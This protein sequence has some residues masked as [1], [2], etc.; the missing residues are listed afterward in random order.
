M[1]DFFSEIGEM[2]SNIFGF[3]QSCIDGITGFIESLKGFWGTAMMILSMFPPPV[4]GIFVAAFAL[5]VAFVVIELLR[6]FL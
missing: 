4:V 5:L 2:I 6:D 1:F 3:F